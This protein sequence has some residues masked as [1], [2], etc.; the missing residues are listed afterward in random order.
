MSLT[1]CAYAVI[2]FFLGVMVIP[3]AAAWWLTRLEK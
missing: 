1:L 3:T 2:G